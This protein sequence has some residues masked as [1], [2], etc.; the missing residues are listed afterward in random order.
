MKR[1]LII[2]IVSGWACALLQLAALVSTRQEL[3][4]TQQMLEKSEAYAIRQFAVLKT[5]KQKLEMSHTHLKEMGEIARTER[6]MAK[7]NAIQRD[8]LSRVLFS[9]PGGREAYVKFREEYDGP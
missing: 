9:L 7:Q 8:V 1:L 6:A 4:T 5:T 2:L 3:Q